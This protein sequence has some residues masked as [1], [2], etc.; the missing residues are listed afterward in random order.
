MQK[1]NIGSI[2]LGGIGGLTAILLKNKNYNVF[3]SKKIKKKN[4]NLFL[5][6]SYYGNLTAKIKIDATLKKNKCNFYL[7]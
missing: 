5:K 7:F 4:I 1:I 2:G 3:S 6:S